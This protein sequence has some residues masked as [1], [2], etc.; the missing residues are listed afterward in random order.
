VSAANAAPGAHLSVTDHD[1]Y[2]LQAI[3]T[4]HPGEDIA[5]LECGQ[6]QHARRFEVVGDGRYLPS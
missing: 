4:E 3:L 2:S 1:S 5:A 6:R